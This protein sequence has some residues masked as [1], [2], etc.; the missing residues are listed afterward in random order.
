MTKGQRNYEKYNKK[1]SYRGG[2]RATRRLTPTAL[3]I[4]PV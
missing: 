2:T 3:Y 1:L 4:N